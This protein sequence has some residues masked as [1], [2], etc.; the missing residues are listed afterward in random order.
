MF[1]LKRNEPIT[2]N[3]TTEPADQ[4]P[5]RVVRP[6]VDI[7][8][9]DGSFILIADLPGCDERGVDITV[10]RGVLTLRATPKDQAPGGLPA[11]VRE[12][13]DR[14]YERSFVLPDAID[15]DG[16]AAQMR[17]GVLAVTLPKAPAARPQRIA[18]NAG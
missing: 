8:E 11:L 14:L 15:R 5:R 17:D 18:V 3:P 16:V 9:E 7:R 2:A 1:S 10:E 12:R 13:G 6:P 4:R